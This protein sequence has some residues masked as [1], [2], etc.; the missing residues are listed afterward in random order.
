[1]GSDSEKL[2]LL[3]HSGSVRET[4]K[5]SVSYKIWGPVCSITTTIL[6]AG[7]GNRPLLSTMQS[8]P[9]SHQPSSTEKI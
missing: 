1:M 6:V 2:L 8:L 4:G 5:G 7:L 3:V 9:G